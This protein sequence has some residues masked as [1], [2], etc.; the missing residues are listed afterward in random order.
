MPYE[1]YLKLNYNWEGNYLQ[2]C[3]A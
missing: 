3:T 2:R 1:L